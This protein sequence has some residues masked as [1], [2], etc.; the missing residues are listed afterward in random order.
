MVRREYLDV[1]SKG[2]NGTTRASPLLKPIPA[3]GISPGL[4]S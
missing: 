4:H 3:K 1:A 2:G